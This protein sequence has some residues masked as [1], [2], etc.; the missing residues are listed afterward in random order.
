MKQHYLV[1]FALL[2]A[3]QP[4]THQDIHT[5]SNNILRIYRNNYVLD[6]DGWSN[7]IWLSLS[8]LQ[9]GE[10]TQQGK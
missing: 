3:G 7:T 2:Q 1:S 9:R 10:S 4:P 8:Q 5:L 6:V